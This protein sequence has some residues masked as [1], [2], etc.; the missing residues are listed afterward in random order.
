M[1]L[2]VGA[3]LVW[4]ND[5][6]NSTTFVLGLV[7]FGLG[8]LVG[9]LGVI[10]LGRNRTAFPRPL[11]DS[12]LVQTGVYSVIRHPLYASVMLASVGWALVWSSVPS[13]IVACVLGLYL[14]AKARTEERWLQER[15]S[16]YDGYARRVKRFIPGV[17]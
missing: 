4:H 1:I 10:H 15:Y 2:A 9:V 11:A 7:L 5:W 6:Q 14:D 17:Y 13:L 8:G 12:A 16:A 3:A